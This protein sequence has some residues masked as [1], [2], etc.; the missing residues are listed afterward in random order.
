MAFW[1]LKNKLVPS[2]LFKFVAGF[3]TFEQRMELMA[4]N[5]RDINTKGRK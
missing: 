5:I 2:V 1:L 3:I 4:R